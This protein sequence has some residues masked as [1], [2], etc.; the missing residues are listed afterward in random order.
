[1]Q[2][3]F[4]LHRPKIAGSE[5]VEICIDD[6]QCRPTNDCFNIPGNIR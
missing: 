2:P 6:T 1:M 3:H 4:D 5:R